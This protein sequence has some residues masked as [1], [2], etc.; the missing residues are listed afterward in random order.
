[1]S[2]VLTFWFWLTPIL[3]TEDK[4]PRRL[5]FL[6]AGNPLA[7]FVRAY[8]E[9]LLS[10]RLPKL[11]DLAIA[12]VCATAAFV[13]GGLFFR[14]MKRGFA[15]VLLGRRHGLVTTLSWFA[16]PTGTPVFRNS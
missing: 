9:T 12:A 7:Y 10:A 11:D 2:V 4:F 1:L 13:I 3:I 8:R 14:H 16:D 5:R 6:I 15:D